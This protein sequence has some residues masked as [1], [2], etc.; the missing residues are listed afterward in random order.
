[1][2]HIIT[3]NN[4][5]PSEY[6]EADF[7]FKSVILKNISYSNKEDVP[8]LLCN[9]I[10]GSFGALFTMPISAVYA[11]QQSKFD[12]I[13]MATTFDEPFLGPFDR[14]DIKLANEFSEDSSELTFEI[15][16]K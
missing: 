4:Q 3:L 9:W 12:L 14:L 2:K 6:F 5:I 13:K 16:L 7:M 15:E 10:H 1:M 8:T 11:H